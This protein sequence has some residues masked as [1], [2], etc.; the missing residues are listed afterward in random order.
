M[1]GKRKDGLENKNKERGIKMK[2]KAAERSARAAQEKARATGEEQ[3]FIFPMVPCKGP[4]G[5]Y[6]RTPAVGVKPSGE[7]TFYPSPF[8]FHS[9][10]VPPPK[11]EPL[12][13]FNEA[14]KVLHNLMR[15]MK[16]YEPFAA[17]EYFSRREVGWTNE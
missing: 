3:I 17:Y 10:I 5:G 6:H 7:W 14:V 16:K 8:G 12:K 9:I 15:E 13:G 4:C 1:N 11:P 2:S